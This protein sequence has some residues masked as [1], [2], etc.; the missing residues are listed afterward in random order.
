MW[1]STLWGTEQ[2]GKES[3][4]GRPLQRL[5]EEHLLK[6]LRDPEEGGAVCSLWSL[7]GF[8]ISWTGS[9][10][11]G[12]P[13]SSS[14]VSPHLQSILLRNTSSPYTF[15]ISPPFTL[16][17]LPLVFSTFIP[18]RL[19]TLDFIFNLPSFLTLSLHSRCNFP[20]SPSCPANSS[21]AV[22]PAWSSLAPSPFLQVG[23]SI[24]I[25]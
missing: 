1:W 9:N 22:L 2:F 4:W 12:D 20:V 23:S 11:G 3:W 6:C 13:L 19:S 16:T 5:V 15:L 24:H 25:Q 7:V 18:T 10:L 8:D 14:S 17:F 21:F